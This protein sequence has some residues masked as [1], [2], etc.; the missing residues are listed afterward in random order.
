MARKR[1][2]KNAD[3]KSVKAPIVQ[4]I[5]VHPWNRQKQD[6]TNWRNATRAAESIIPRRVYLYDLYHDVSTTDGQIIAVWGKRQDAITT[7]NWEFTDKEGN[8]V[9][10]INE[11]IDCIGF[12]NL[13]KQIIDSK[14]WGY[15]MCEA[16]FFI[17][18]NDQNE[19]VVKAIERKNMRPEAGQ[20]ALQTIDQ[21][22]VD[23]NT[24]FYAKTVM[25]FG[26]AKDLG[27]LLS[28]SMYSIFK[29]G[30]I[31]D[32]AEFIEIFGR[33][34]VDAQWDGFDEGQR[35]KLSKAI[36]EMG[37]GGV[38]IRPDGTKL[39]IKNNTGSANGQLQDTFATKMDG[40]ISKALLGTTETTDS[41]SSSGYAQAETHNKQDE[42]KNESDLQFVRRSLN[43]Q[44]IKILKAA[45]FDTRG[46]TF[47]IK[48]NKN[49]NKSEYE[50]HRSMR[51]DLNIPIDDDF[52]YET[53][54]VR[55]P[56]NYD[57]LKK[58]QEEAKKADLD[59]EP[60]KKNAPTPKGSDKEK[61]KSPTGIQADKRR[62]LSWF[63]RILQLFHSAPVPVSKQ[64]AG[65][66]GDHL[67]KIRLAA[68]VGGKV[69]DKIKDDVIERA[70]N[71][72]GRMS[73]DGSLFEFTADTLTIG[74]IQGWRTKPAQLVD[75]GFTYD[76]DDP[77]T[78][79]AFE[80]NLFRFAGA[81][82]LYEAQQLNE[83][84]RKARSFR[85]FYDTA[86]GMLDVH[87]K[88]W[89]ETEYN[90]AISV[91]DMAA[92]Y[93]RLL[94]QT[95][96]FPFWQYKTVGDERVRHSHAL[97]HDI[98]LPWNHGAWKYIMPPG[99]WNCRCWIVP[100]T[101]AEVTK[102]QI[103]ASEERVKEYLAGEAFKKASKGGWGVNRAD[104]GQVFTENQHYIT[105]YL[106]GV[107]KMN[108]LSPK[109]WGL[110]PL[111]QNFNG[112]KFEPKFK[113]DQRDEAIEDF[114]DSLQK[115]TAKKFGITDYNNRTI[116]IDKGTIRKHTTD[117]KEKYQ[118][119]HIYMN[120][121][122]SIVKNPDEVWLQNY[123]GKRYES[124]IY[125]RYYS[126][127]AVVVVCTLNDALELQ[128]ETWHRLDDTNIRKGLL[129]KR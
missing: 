103:K 36:R 31:S 118:E 53:Y 64:V 50:I 73:F 4:Q 6:I 22:G 69:F 13:L 1:N 94:K 124:F 123:R 98:V 102:E 127:Q 46:G 44:F 74:F 119:R 129:I 61:D 125:I 51:N 112:R 79:T 92:T 81:K 15:S 26:E 70:W 28:A 96:T 21:E 67:T 114:T 3:L 58:A 42:K 12:E 39:D 2:I 5:T 108:S 45:G 43:S 104:K 33:G 60:D 115:V 120:E 75:I 99:D 8:P 66:D 78:L 126:D 122:E 117:R 93:N 101:K 55:K 11:L 47:V 32:W 109:E 49:L 71:A 72:K 83:L 62:Q 68:F 30:D 35:Q 87:N 38:I 86:S 24:G 110:K 48:K 54:G 128:I 106:D 52:F 90:T 7:A 27:L 63:R 40:Y 9:D 84:F 19:F 18:D 85:E 107:K 65:A 77:A 23:I 97:L 17:N 113:A 56:D 59:S 20:V 91:G 41:S 88:L 80:M 82:T 16:E 105:D 100:R 34:I 95:D 76:V 14:A 121:I 89:L 37:G 25:Q 116:T 57:E 111:S 10:S 29:R